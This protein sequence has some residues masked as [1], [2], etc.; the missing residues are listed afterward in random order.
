MKRQEVTILMADDDPDDYHLFK[1]VMEETGLKGHV[2]LVTNG[3]ELMDYLHKRGIYGNGKAAQRPAIIILDLNM[4]KK[5]GRH[6]IPELKLDPVLRT[7]P[8]IVFTTSSSP[9]DIQYCY[10]NG[11]SSF[12]IKPGDFQSLTRLI[13]SIWDYWLGTVQL[14]TDPI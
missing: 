6:V 7:I 2:H 1:E 11:A 4:P 10:E 5:D 9:E 14:N 8:I 3:E 13:Q 12:I